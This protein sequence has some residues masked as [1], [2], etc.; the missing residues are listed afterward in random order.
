MAVAVVRAGVLAILLAC[1]ATGLNNGML[2]IS[3]LVMFVFPLGRSEINAPMRPQ[4]DVF[5][6]GL[7][8]TPAMGYSSWNDCSS[9]VT[10]AH[11][12][13]ITQFLLSSGLAA[14]GYIHVS[15]VIRCVVLST[16]RTTPSPC[17]SRAPMKLRHATAGEC[18]RGVA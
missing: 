12:K 1:G 10:E 9:D 2:F 11:I 14:K 17:A 4:F 6:A 13:N 18:R 7:G 5:C 8:R 16:S 3:I 15:T